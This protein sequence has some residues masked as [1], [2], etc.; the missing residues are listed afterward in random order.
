M[1]SLIP[2]PIARRLIVGLLGFRWRQA[3]ASWSRGRIVLT[4]EHLD[5]MSAAEF[6]QCIQRWGRG[7]RGRSP[8]RR[9]RE[10]DRD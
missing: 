1:E 5:R 2:P 4:E 10:P 3:E 9:C 8:R 6:S 7:R